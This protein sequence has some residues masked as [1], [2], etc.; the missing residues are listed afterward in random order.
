[1]ASLC[2]TTPKQTLLFNFLS[3]RDLEDYASVL[4]SNGINTL[5]IF[6]HLDEAAITEFGIP[7]IP[8]VALLNA[9]VELT[10]LMLLR[11]SD[12]DLPVAVAVRTK[13]SSGASSGGGDGSV[14]LSF[15]TDDHRQK[16]LGTLLVDPDSTLQ[17]LIHLLDQTPEINREFMQIY[18]GFDRRSDG[19][20]STNCGKTVAEEWQTMRHNGYDGSRLQNPFIMK[21]SA[22]RAKEI[23]QELALENS[24]AITH[25]LTPP[26]K[27][28]EGSSTYK[29]LKRENGECT[30]RSLGI[31]EGKITQIR[32]NGHLRALGHDDQFFLKTLTG[33]TVTFWFSPSARIDTFKDQIDLMEGIP[34]DQI[35]L[36][37]AGKQLED[38]R[39]FGDYNIQKEATLHLVLRLRNIGHFGTHNDSVC[40]DLLNAENP[41]LASKIS[42][43]KVQTILKEIDSDPDA[44]FTSYPE[45]YS[46]L[47][48]EQCDVLMK[49]VDLGWKDE[50]L[51]SKDFKYMVTTSKLVDLIGDVTTKHLVAKLFNNEH[52]KIIIRRCQEYGHCIKF[53]TDRFSLK[54]M[55]IPLNGED[56]YKG[57]KLVFV[58]SRGFEFPPRPAGSATLHRNNI[59]H[60]VTK[61]IKTEVP[62]Y[63]LFFLKD[64]EDLE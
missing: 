12:D 60:G 46:I 26:V 36:I 11:S 53:H 3:E 4:F 59:A 23:V 27:T 25:G 22:E 2:S 63:G 56:D 44:T 15:I 21:I 14:C 13:S 64:Q 7:R 41:T 58:T 29:L 57:G 5:G 6:A 10:T 39:T 42:S 48:K 18:W 19:S 51:C 16:I 31:E 28:Q 45:K 24:E 49:H 1:M 30:L 62:R 52:T 38:G 32:L 34:S 35:R 61:L 43:S 20:A 33:K 50:G 9:V 47:N 8:G 17:S 40:L 54:T 55:Q 37:F